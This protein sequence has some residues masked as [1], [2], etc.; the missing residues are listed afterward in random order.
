MTQRILVAIDS[1]KGSIGAADGAV[2]LREG[3]LQVRP[4]D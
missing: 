2:A 3:W 1:F 4:D